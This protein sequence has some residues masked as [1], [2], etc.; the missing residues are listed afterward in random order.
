MLRLL[1]VFRLDC[2]VVLF[3]SLSITATEWSRLLVL[4]YEIAYVPQE[5]GGASLVVPPSSQRA[6]AIFLFLTD[7]FTFF[8][9]TKSQDSGA[10]KDFRNHLVQISHV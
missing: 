2:G 10:G 5:N 9:V 1:S 7:H 8:E 6:G 4:F 3:L